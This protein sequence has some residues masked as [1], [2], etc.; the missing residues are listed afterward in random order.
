MEHEFWH[1]CWGSNK[2][3]FHKSA[4]HKLLVEY[5]TEVCSVA[6]PRVLVPLCGKSL[7]MLWL[8]N[9]GAFVVGAELSEIAVQQ[10]FSDN[11]LSHRTEQ[12]GE[13]TAYIGEQCVIYCGDFFALN[14]T[15]VGKIDLV[16][17]RAA[18]IA[19]P[20]SMREQYVAKVGELSN[21]ATQKL[22]IVIDYLATEYTKPP[23]AI[24]D[25]MVAKLYEQNYTLRKLKTIIDPTEVGSRLNNEGIKDVHE[26]VFLLN[27][28]A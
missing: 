17:D 7:D 6:N 20:A 14:Q 26:S 13:L 11:Q 22:L 12:I 23:F 28:I 24:N 10:F 16:Y 25:E 3:A 1:G 19:L 21:L 5:Y 4:A 18:L 8:M 2:I 15:L 27:K 9:Q